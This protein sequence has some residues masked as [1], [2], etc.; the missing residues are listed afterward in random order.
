MPHGR[1]PRRRRAPRNKTRGVPPT[2]TSGRKKQ[3][4]EDTFYQ[5]SQGRE[6]K[7]QNKKEKKKKQS[8]I[9]VKQYLLL[10]GN[11]SIYSFWKNLAKEEKTRILHVSANEIIDN[12]ETL[13]VGSPELDSKI[14]KFIKDDESMTNLRF[15]FTDALWN[16]GVMDISVDPAWPSINGIS[17]QEE[18][19]LLLEQHL[20]FI[21]THKNI[22]CKLFIMVT[23]YLWKSNWHWILRFIAFCFACYISYSSRSAVKN[24]V[25][26]IFKCAFGTNPQHMD[27]SFHALL[28]GI[29]SVSYGRWLRWYHVAV[30]IAILPLLLIEI[31]RITSNSSDSNALKYIR[32]FFIIVSQLMLLYISWY[33]WFVFFFASFFFFPSISVTLVSYFLSIISN[34][35]CMRCNLMDRVE[36]Q[37]DPTQEDKCCTPWKF[38]LWILFVLSLM[39]YYWTWSS[40][41]W[42]IFNFLIVILCMPNMLGLIL[43]KILDSFGNIENLFIGNVLSG[44]GYIFII[45]LLSL[46]YT[47]QKCCKKKEA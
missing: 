28:A 30:I 12:L 4:N 35:I 24:I 9:E 8:N 19:I 44:I 16:G 45:L 25:R 43:M 38:L 11:T 37:F 27:A 41:F 31:E 46:F 18:V 3:K 40:W 42:V 29:I 47:C 39:C 14:S 17:I 10:D 2:T 13:G 6:D 7:K 15:N 23:F 20:L 34:L 5:Q 32:G 1:N 21:Y 36:N 33:S 26:N 22:L